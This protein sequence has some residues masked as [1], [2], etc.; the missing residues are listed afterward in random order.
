MK[1]QEVSAHHV[2]IVGRL[3]IGARS[4]VVASTNNRVAQDPRLEATIL[5]T[6]DGLEGLSLARVRDTARFTG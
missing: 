1:R 4:R 6:R 3:K 5:L 2:I